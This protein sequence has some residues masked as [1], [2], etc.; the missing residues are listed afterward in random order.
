MGDEV[1][2]DNV[3][4]PILPQDYAEGERAGY[5]TV[6]D[7]GQIGDRYGAYLQDESKLRADGTTEIAF[8]RTTAD[9]SAILAQRSAQ[10]I[11]TTVSGARTGIAGAAVPVEGGALLSLDRMKGIGTPTL[12][13]DAAQGRQATVR[14]TRVA[15]GSESEASPEGRWTIRVQAGVTL[16]ELND[17][18][19]SFAP[20]DPALQRY[21]NNNCDTSI[22]EG[23]IVESG[24]GQLI[25]PVDPTE[26][27][28]A[29]GGMVATNASGA[30]TF[31]YGPMRDWV[32]AVTVVLAD[33]SV[34]ELTR[35]AHQVQNRSLRL[36]DSYGERS[37]TASALKKPPTKNTI[38]YPF[39]EGIDAVD[40]FIGQEGT[41]GVVTEV[42]L[43]LTVLPRTRLFYLQ[44]FKSD[45]AALEFVAAIR[46]PDDKVLRPVAIEYAD[47]HSL[48]LVGKSAIAK[49]STIARMVRD[50]FQ[51]MVYIEQP[52]L[53]PDALTV[54]YELLAVILEGLG[55]SMENSYAGTDDRALRELKEFRHAIPEQ[56]NSTIARRK[57][58]HPTLH[59]VAT[60]MAVPDSDLAEMYFLYRSVLDE[61]EIEYAIFGHA[62]NNHFHVNMMPCDDEELVRAKK[63]YKLFAEEAVRRGGSVAAE[64]GIGRLKKAF[65]G[66]Q[67]GPE[68]LET[69]KSI[70]R[71]FDPKLLLNRGVLFDV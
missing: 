4:Q 5:E 45:E 53:F 9:V 50:E 66:I 36:T 11:P 64:H 23:E 17:Y 63:I 29:I 35:G 69:L 22:V 54:S 2:T 38:G 37:L 25:F 15:G 49:T 16:Q 19:A 21:L 33:G 32:R 8:P 48:E 13:D 24:T 31:A 3:L 68:E 56:I 10:G 52:L 28:A 44:F 27:S 67:Y 20:N 47:R 58:A 6:R 41:L 7:Q 51:A 34:L 12:L 46:N 60:D 43:Y 70:R 71:F 40:L 26:T 61:A 62:G 57:V 39:D 55:E 65:L 1:S 30:R 42:E 14:R 18:L 59:K